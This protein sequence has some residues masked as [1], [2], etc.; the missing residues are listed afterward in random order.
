MI[1]TVLGNYCAT[2]AAI[3]ETSPHAN[4]SEDSVLERIWD[5]RGHAVGKM[6]PGGLV[7]RTDLD[8]AEWE[9]VAGGFRNPYDLDFTTDGE[10]FTYDADME[11][12]IGTPWYR[13]PRFVHVV[14]G[15]EF[16]WRGGSVREEG[17]LCCGH[18]CL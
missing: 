4:W 12:D 6:A 3:A 8:G 13:S 10:L 1:W 2:P 11:W 5:P 7:L 16:G 17:R 14:S 18:C 15:G 9:I